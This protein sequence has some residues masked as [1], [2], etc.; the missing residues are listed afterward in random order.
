VQGNFKS[1]TMM[2]FLSLPRVA[3]SKEGLVADMMTHAAVGRGVTVGG[4]G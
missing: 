2:A 4:G 1:W 3:V